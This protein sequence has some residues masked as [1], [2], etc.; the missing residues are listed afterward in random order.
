MTYS[1]PG[2]S[3]TTHVP[4]RPSC[5]FYLMPPSTFKAVSRNSTTLPKNYRLRTGAWYWVIQNQSGSCITVSVDL[6]LSSSNKIK[7]RRKNNRIF[8][9]LSATYLTRGISMSWTGCSPA[10]F[11]LESTTIPEIGLHLPGRTSRSDCN[12]LECRSDSIW[13]WSVRIS[14]WR[15][16]GRFPS[17]NS[18]GLVLPNP[19]EI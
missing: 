6:N 9:T 19:W 12:L 1:L 4:L 17:T 5:L 14:R 16:R 3:S 18:R 15:R 8:I 11:S 13:W 2:R 10:Q 7:R